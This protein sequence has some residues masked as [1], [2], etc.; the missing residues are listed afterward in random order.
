MSSVVEDDRSAE[1][2]RVLVEP[3][4]FRD[5]AY[6][7]GSWI[8]ADE[9]LRVENPADGSLIGWVPKLATREMEAAVAAADSAFPMWSDL[10]ARERSAILTRWSSLMLEHVEDLAL[11]ITVEQGKPLAESRGEVAYGASFLEW[12]AAEGLRT[13]GRTIPSHLPGAQLRVTTEPI[14]VVAAITPWNFPSAMIARKVGAALAI[15]CPVIV[16][17]ARE[18]PFSALALAV[19]AE[20][21]GI[22]PGVLSVLTGDPAPMFEVLAQAPQVRA[23]SFTGST[24]VG[25]TVLAKCASTVKRVS[26]EL[27]GHAPFIVFDDTDVEQAARLC[28]AAKFVTSGQDCL[29]PNRIFVQ[30]SVYD[31]FVEHLARAVRELRVG[32]G[33]G[34]GVHVG[35][36]ISEAAAEKVQ[37]HV[38]DAVAHG[39]RV[40]V[41]GARHRLGRTFF[42]PT[43]LVDVQDTMRVAT[44][45]TFGPV[46][47]VLR[48][49][50]EDEVIERA[51]HTEYGLAAYVMTSSLRRAERLSRALQCGMVAVNTA[52]F[53]GAPIPFGGHKQSGLGREGA[54]DGITEFSEVKYTC[55]GEAR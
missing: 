10:L 51:N 39:A 33:R 13:Y 18:T 50:D 48:F 36:L 26:L 47:P 31:A 45:E 24:N 34:D 8:G 42:Q 14:G 52:T 41:G 43:L 37:A 20:E 30:D 40:V 53:T 44:E 55:V 11:L 28:A 5:R 25:R 35:P 1:L 17:P 9:T 19:L 54:Q 4:L 29:A 49:E 38:T 2:A 15:G 22:P 16:L 12:F 21:A 23:V 46:A 27:G 6:L 3:R 32:D 7:A